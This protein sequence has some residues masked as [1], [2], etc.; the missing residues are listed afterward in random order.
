MFSSYAT[1]IPKKFT[2]LM[3]LSSKKI[4]EIAHILQLL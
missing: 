4:W 2:K 3:L 1:L